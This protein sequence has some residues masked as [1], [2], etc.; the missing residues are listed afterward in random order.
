MK[1]EIKYKMN[2]FRSVTQ[3]CSTLCGPM[4]GNTPGFPVY[5]QL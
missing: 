3:L 5:H 2:Q 1:V 4:D